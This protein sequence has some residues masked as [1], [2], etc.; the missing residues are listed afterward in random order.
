VT[1]N[2]GTYVGN[3]YTL[4]GLDQS[5]TIIFSGLVTPNNEGYGPIVTNFIV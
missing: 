5:N 1:V 3:K 2:K 4:N